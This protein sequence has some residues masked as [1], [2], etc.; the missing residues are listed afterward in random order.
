MNNFHL[1]IRN[2]EALKKFTYCFNGTLI[3][4]KFQS[5]YWKYKS[6]KKKDAPEGG[7]FIKIENAY[8]DRSHSANASP[9]CIGGT[10]WKRFWSFY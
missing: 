1:K 10:D 2:K 5:Y 8:Q 7:W 9:D 4:N 6:W 3:G